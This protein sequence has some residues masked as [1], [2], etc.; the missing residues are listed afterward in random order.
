MRLLHRKENR[1][2]FREQRDE[3]LALFLQR[4]S[5]LFKLLFGA[6]KL[7]FQAY[8]GCFCLILILAELIDLTV[9]VGDLLLRSLDISGDPVKTAAGSFLLLLYLA[10]MLF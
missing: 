3:L 7:L 4:S 10:Q 2:T 9:K 8:I 5:S 1:E 6:F